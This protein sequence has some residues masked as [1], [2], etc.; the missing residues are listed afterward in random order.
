MHRDSLTPR[1]CKVKTTLPV[2]SER[3]LEWYDHHRRILPWRAL[4][5]ATPDP[6]HVWLSEIMLQ[7][8][9][10]ATVGPYYQAFIKKFPTLQALAKAPEEDVLRLWSGLGYYRRAR[11]LH[12]CARQVVQEH[13]GVFP[14]DEKALLGLPGVGTYTAAAIRAIAYDRPANVV[15]GNVERVVARYLRLTKP[16]PSAKNLLRQKAAT[17]LPAARHGDYAQA[18]M[19]L[20]ATI[21]TPRSPKCTLCPLQQDCAVAGKAAAEK[22]PRREAQKAKPLRY[23][24][25]FLIINRAGDI[26]IRRRGDEGLFAGLWEVPSTAWHEGKPKTPAIY[27][28]EAPCKAKWQWLT[29]EVRHVFTHFDLRLQVTVARVAKLP[30]GYRWCAPENMK[31]EALPSLMHKIVRFALARV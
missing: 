5:G 30:K 9:T 12:A 26:A 27:V 11:N 20:G 23:G 2:F 16:M 21:C 31:D 10:V 25:A 15:D 8:T 24:A 28:R 17:L 19:D 6:Y 3:L 4:P 1:R 22:L 7:Q 18:L 14:S 13:K 29:G